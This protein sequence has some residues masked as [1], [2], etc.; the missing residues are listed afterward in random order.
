MATGDKKTWAVI[1]LAVAAGASVAA[2]AIFAFETGP[3]RV[4]A[5]LLAVLLTG[6]LCAGT[7]TYR[8]ERSN[9]A[10]R[11]RS[12]LEATRKVVRTAFVWWP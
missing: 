6:T 3:P 8:L 12:I 4:V 2:A 9:E 1:I 7:S 5:V 10:S 11:S